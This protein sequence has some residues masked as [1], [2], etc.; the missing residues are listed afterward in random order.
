MA[1]VSSLVLGDDLTFSSGELHTTNHFHKYTYTPEMPDRFF[2]PTSLRKPLVRL[3]GPESHHLRDV[4][5]L[6]VG[7][8]VVLFDGEGTEADAT[9]TAFGKDLTE[10]EMGAA[11]VDEPAVTRIVLGVAVP[12]GERFRWL[13]EKATEIGVDQ[14]VPVNTSRSVID[15]GDTKLDRMRSLVI[16]ACKQSG[17][18]RLMQ[19]DAP[20]SWKE[21]VATATESESKLF[22]A[23]QTGEPLA[24]VALRGANLSIALGIGPEGGFVSSE[25]ELARESGAQIVGLGKN[26]LRIETAAIAL[27]AY[28]KFATING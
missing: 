7:Q 18:N 25:L 8:S 10:L 19:I 24:N 12:K 21:F 16:A 17:R 26:A 28:V 14:L 4:M 11:R 20:C 6:R 15:P 1:C 23:D 27:A 2:A 9:I 5:R 22:V 3:T 13:I